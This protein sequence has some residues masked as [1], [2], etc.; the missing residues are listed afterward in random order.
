[1]SIRFSERSCLKKAK[2]EADRKR[3]C[4]LTSGFY[5]HVYSCAC[6]PEHVCGHVH[7]IKG[8]SH[9]HMN[10]HTCMKIYSGK[11]SFCSREGPFSS[12]WPK[13]NKHVFSCQLVMI[14]ENAR[15]TATSPC[16][17]PIHRLPGA[18]EHLP[19]AFTRQSPSLLVSWQ[20]SLVLGRW[21][22]VWED[23][24]LDPWDP[25]GQDCFYLG[26]RRSGSK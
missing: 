10:M 7:T 4:S 19:W 9:M 14:M 20:T 2:M 15:N 24:D 6:T 5:N 11:Y 22:C 18:G 1:M 26:V 3:R 23:N 8:L 25:K 21:R 16:S 17:V 13:P 12:L